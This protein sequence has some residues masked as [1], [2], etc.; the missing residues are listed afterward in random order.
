[1]DW[2]REYLPQ[3]RHTDVSEPVYSRPPRRRLAPRPG[4]AIVRRFDEWAGSGS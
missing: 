1:M 2:M 4:S 3:F